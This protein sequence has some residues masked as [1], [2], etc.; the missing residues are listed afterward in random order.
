[1]TRISPPLKHSGSIVARMAHGSSPLE[2]PPPVEA[3]LSSVASWASLPEGDSPPPLSAAPKPRRESTAEDVF[4][5][6]RRKRGLQMRMEQLE[7]EL[8]AN[9]SRASSRD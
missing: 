8:S 9:P 7:R 4:R 2:P 3:P 1:M 6:A 5:E